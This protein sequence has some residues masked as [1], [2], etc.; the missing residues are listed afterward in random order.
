MKIEISK[1]FVLEA[2]K[3]ACSDWKKRIEKELPELFTKRVKR[4]RVVLCKN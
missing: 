3:A 1:E 4:W 2:H